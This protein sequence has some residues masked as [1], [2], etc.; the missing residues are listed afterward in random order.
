MSVSLSTSIA[1]PIAKKPVRLAFTASSG[2]FVRAWCTAAPLGSK[3]RAALDKDASARVHAFDADSGR[4]LDYTFEVSGA[5]QF[6]AQELVK[7]AAQYGGGYQNAPNSAPAERLLGETAI[8]VHVAA[9]LKASLGTS[10][11]QADL[12]LYVTDSTIQPTLLAVHGVAS[13]AIQGAKTDRAKT[14]AQNAGVVAAVAALAGTSAATSLGTLGTVATDFI[15]KFNAHIVG[16]SFHATTDGADNHIPRDFRNP[17]TADALKRTLGRILKSLSNHI[18]ND[19][20]S[21]PAGTGVAQWHQLGGEN[22]VDWTSLPLFESS[23]KISEHVRALADAWRSYE[24]HRGSA[25]HTAPDNTN[26]LS[27]L[28]PLLHVHELFLAEL[29][30]LS[31]SAPLTDNSAKTLLVHG[32]GFEEI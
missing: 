29:A 27:A 23:S 32:A 26:V 10:T 25:A 9:G 15:D 14:A 22:V 17:T 12:L 7:G 1:V 16:G 4:Q 5:Y 11:D 2:N 24:A 6:A 18:R 31:P 21:N 8:A 13:P 30:K 3:L 19:T 28:P 20:Y